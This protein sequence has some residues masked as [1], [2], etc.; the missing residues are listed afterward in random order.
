VPDP[1][2]RADILRV[3]C[4]HVCSTAAELPEAACIPVFLHVLAAFLLAVP[5]LPFGLIECCMYERA[6]T[7]HVP[8]TRLSPKP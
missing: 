2:A 1:V 4:V 5:A 3:R 6:Q 8:H 7:I